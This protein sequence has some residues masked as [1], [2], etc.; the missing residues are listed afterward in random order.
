MFP[1]FKKNSKTNRRTGQVYWFFA[2]FL[3]NFCYNICIFSKRD[4]LILANQVKAT[5]LR[6][7]EKF[8]T[9]NGEEQIIF[10]VSDYT[11]DII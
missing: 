1:L 8:R 6:E 3:C 5:E 11:A 4:T 7:T 10:A 9:I 2:L